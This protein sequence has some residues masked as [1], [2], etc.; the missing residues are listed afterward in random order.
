MVFG[1]KRRPGPRPPERGSLSRK[2]TPSASMLRRSEPARYGLGGNRVQSPRAPCL[3]VRIAGC[4]A[5]RRHLH[6]A[7][8]VFI[9]GMRGNGN[10]HRQHHRRCRR[11]QSEHEL[12]RAFGSR[13]GRPPSDDP[14]LALTVRAPRSLLARLDEAR[15]E[16]TRGE[17]V[18]QALERWLKSIRRQPRAGS[19][20]ALGFLILATTTYAEAAQ[21]LAPESALAQVTSVRV[22][23][24]DGVSGN[25]L[26]NVEAVRNKISSNLLRSS[27]GVDESSLYI[28]AAGFNGHS[29]DI[30]NRRIA[31]VVSS[32]FYL[33]WYHPGTG[34][35]VMIEA[36][37]VHSGPDNQDS[38][39]ISEAE[40]F[41]DLMTSAI[42][43]AR[44]NARQ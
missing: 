43:K 12:A 41:S 21:I 26:L 31:C 28:V 40:S 1:I 27:I 6:L 8:T 18:R 34:L 32:R 25:C 5:G 19:G 17:V 15:G 44:M 14:M 42:L 29:I 36:D 16:R 10:V 39:A 35:I 22:V 33:S 24:Y 11:R 37:G 30:G 13:I 23:T 9:G 2:C 38:G 20:C 3:S 7:T 4:A